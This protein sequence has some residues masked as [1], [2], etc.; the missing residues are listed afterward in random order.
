MPLDTVTEDGNRV[1]KLEERKKWLKGLAQ[2]GVRGIMVDVWWG[3]CETG[4][5]EY[6]FAGYVELCK[7]L[8]ELGLKLQAV[9]SF[10]QCGGNVGDSVTVKLP[11]YAL[12]T[13]RS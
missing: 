6:N 7:L 10:H 3:L 12:E 5:G 2:S 11:K 4:P 13:A 1:N 8:Q 9:M